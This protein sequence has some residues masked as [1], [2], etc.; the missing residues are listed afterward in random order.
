MANYLR[1]MIK[2]MIFYATFKAILLLKYLNFLA[3]NKLIFLIISYFNLC[4]FN[5][6]LS[7]ISYIFILMSFQYFPFRDIPEFSVLVS[8]EISTGVYCKKK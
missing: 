3:T 2:N 1:V 4:I 6:I 5:N 7:S 8:H